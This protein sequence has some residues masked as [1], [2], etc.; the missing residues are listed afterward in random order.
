LEALGCELPARIVHS[1][2]VRA[3]QTA[4]IIRDTA[5]ADCNTVLQADADLREGAPCVPTPNWW[6]PSDAD[7]ARDSVRIERSFRRWFHRDVDV[8]GPPADDVPVG[9][10][11][12][13]LTP[14]A[15]AAAAAPA[16]A[17]GS[18]P[19]AP[20]QAAPVAARHRAEILVCH[21]NVIRFLVLRALQLP[22]DAWLRL[23]V[24]HAS[25]TTVAITCEGDVLLQGLGDAG[26][27]EADLVT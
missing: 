7:V 16:V 11:R 21:G 19:V 26:H 23:V 4:Q 20:P 22:P 6:K 2:F 8:A 15:A 24:P 25:I 10:P 1:T 13:P 5:F 27:I 17:E 18:T 9:P 12:A 14:V 3:A